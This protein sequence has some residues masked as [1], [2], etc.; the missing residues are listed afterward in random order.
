MPTYGQ[1]FHVGPLLVKRVPASS[2]SYRIRYL[3]HWRGYLCFSTIPRKDIATFGKLIDVTSHEQLD[4]EQDRYR[5]E[6]GLEAEV[7]LAYYEVI[8]TDA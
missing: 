5:A 6:M 8:D 7:L 4:H 1:A 2:A 3:Q